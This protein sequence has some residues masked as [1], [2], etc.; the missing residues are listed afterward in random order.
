MPTPPDARPTRPGWRGGEKAGGP[1]RGAALAA[2]VPRPGRRDQVRRQR[3]DRRGAASRRSPATWCSCGCAGIRPVVVHGG[4]PQITR[5]ARAAGPAGGVPRRPAGHHPGDD[6]R[7]ADGAG[8]PGRP[9]AGRADQPARA[10]RGRACPARTPGCSPRRGAPR[11]SA[12]RPV[13][14]GLVGDVVEVDP[15]GGARHRGRR[16]DPGGRGRGPGRRRAGLQHQRR[17]RG[18]RAR[19]RARAR[20]SS[21]CS[22]T[23]RACTRTT[24]TRTR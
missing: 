2:A 16:A 8:R 10:V 21:S 9:G 13:D 7:R 20:R 17:Q 6:R 12:A 24:R 5:D 18:R 11:W 22:P 14:I 23:S 4:G 1:G 3:H 19:G 15:V